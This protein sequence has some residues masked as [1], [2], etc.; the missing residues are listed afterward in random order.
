MN[1]QQNTVSCIDDDK[2]FNNLG[3]DK[4]DMLM[5]EYDTQNESDEPYLIGSD[6]EILGYEANNEDDAFER[7]AIGREASSEL[8]IDAECH[9]GGEGVVETGYDVVNYEGRGDRMKN[10]KTSESNQ[11]TLPNLTKHDYTNTSPSK[12]MGKA[13]D[14]G[15]MNEFYSNSRLHHLSMWKSELK[16][17][18]TMIHKASSKKVNV[19]TLNKKSERCIMHIDMDSFFVSVALKE[20]PELKGKPVA[21]CHASKGNLA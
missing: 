20:R 16:R 12:G 2:L 1:A 3:D 11:V 17:F 4:G 9:D 14:P 10:N 13:G 7:S 6:T 18:A 15:F 21:V 8:K 5:D 19:K